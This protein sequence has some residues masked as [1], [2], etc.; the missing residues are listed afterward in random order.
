VACRDEVTTVD[1]PISALQFIDEHII[2][3]QETFD[4]SRIGGLSS[5]DYHEG[6]WYLISDDKSDTRFYAAAIQ[7]DEKEINTLFFLSKTS[8]LNTD[9]QLFNAS[10]VDPESMRFDPSLGNLVWTSEGNIKKGINPFVRVSTTSGQFVKEFTLPPLF[11]ANA[12]TSGPRLNGTFEGLSLDAN[13]TGYWVSMEEPLIQDGE[14][15]D[16]FSDEAFPIRISHIDK[17]T[18]AFD[19]QYTYLL[20]KVV[21][22]PIPQ[23]GFSV[24]GVVEILAVDESTLLVLE[25]SYSEGYTDNGNNVRIYKVT[26]DQAT[27]VSG[28]TSLK[29]TTYTPVKKTLLLDF[30]Q[31]KPQLDQGRVDNIE[32]MTFGPRLANG[33]L[34]L[35][36]ISDNNFNPIQVSQLLVFEVIP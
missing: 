25:R 3:Y 6:I 5:I 17:A 29:E 27:D 23:D 4:S 36:L 15:S 11:H 24:N 35:A 26:M 31:I 10:E 7:Y 21:R 20:D 14:K 2:P 1:S 33:H 22:K 12:P 30:E 18:G 32:G 28:I 19:R 13:Q 34:T 8:L 9:S 16:Y